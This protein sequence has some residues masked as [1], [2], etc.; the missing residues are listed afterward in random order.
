MAEGWCRHLKNDKIEAFS[1]GIE[2]HGLNPNAVK[3]MADAGV[4]ISEQRSKLV[5]DL[6]NIEFDYVVTVCGHANENCPIFTGRAK[7]IHV[8]FNDPPK[9]GEKFSDVNLKLDCYRKVRDQLKEFIIG[10]PDNIKYKGK[11]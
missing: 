11:N 7:I 8:P 6:A 9:M 2:K 5:T 1:A 3:V 4:D 10:L